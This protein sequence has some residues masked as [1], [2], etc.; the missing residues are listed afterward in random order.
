MW[1]SV[2]WAGDNVGIG[3]SLDW[4]IMEVFSNLDDPVILCKL[5]AAQ[6]V[7]NL[8]Q[9]A[10]LWPLLL[11]PDPGTAWVAGAAHQCQAGFVP[12]QC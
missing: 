11:W 5:R 2:L 3:H 1:R 6:L 10:E 8:S 7:S 4:M 12:I 9:L